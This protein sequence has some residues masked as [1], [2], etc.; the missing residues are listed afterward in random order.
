MSDAQ[1]K[2][3][4]A[5]TSLVIEQPFFGSL[6]LSLHIQE[7]TT[8]DTAWVDGRT[9]GFNPVFIDS[10]THEKTTA[11]VAH[12]V[13]HCALGHP[14]RRDARSMNNWNIACDKTINTELREAG[15]TLPN[16]AYYADGDEVGKSSEW[17]FSRMGE[18]PKDDP[19]GDNNGDS[20]GELRDA[21]NGTDGNGDPSPTEAEWKERVIGAMAQAKLAG[22]IPAGMARA[23]QQALKPRLDVRSLL[24]RFF[25]ERAQSDYTWSKPNT[26]YIAQ[27]LYLPSL[28]SHSLGNVAIMVDTS[29]SIDATSLDYA[30][31]IVESV[32]EECNP[33]S[34]TVYYA[35]AKV[36][37]VERFE[38]GEPLVW[39]PKGGGGTN[40]IPV[41]QAIEE[42]GEAVCA[43]CITDLDGTFPENGPDI[44]V[45]WLATTDRIA[46][47]GETVSIDR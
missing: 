13:M 1:K 46:P 26:R 23:I 6:A 11:L 20:L 9:L 27:G 25:S 38:Q 42:D 19:Q 33:L 34:V 22:K 3:M 29:G 5:R 31:G 16:D 37:G 39:Q 17:I 44:P 10:L 2:M 12:E 18:D 4:A 8:C 41:L 47:F 36:C 15:F 43:L 30:R 45:I 7:D 40:F 14:W 21:P 35:D 28:E 24:L 32:I